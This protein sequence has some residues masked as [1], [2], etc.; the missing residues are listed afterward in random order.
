MASL[1]I[2]RLRA[3]IDHPRT[4]DSERQVAQRML[5]RILGS[6]PVP[7][8]DRNY[9]SRHSRVGRHASLSRIADMIRDDIALARVVFSGAA[10]AIAVTDPI[11]DAPTQIVYR[12]ETPFDAEIVVAIDG[13]PEDWGWSDGVVSPALQ[14]LA[15]ELAAIMNSYNHDGAVVGKRFFGRV[16]AGNE[17]LA[18]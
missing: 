3:L 10:G 17:T 5:D 7:S 8:D 18:R 13:V 9:G 4:G 11:G 15:D 2:V 1:R 14:A 6:R 16:R 12:V